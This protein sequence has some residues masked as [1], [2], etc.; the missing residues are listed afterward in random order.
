MVG[1][2]SHRSMEA[3]GE[4]N[5]EVRINAPGISFHLGENPVESDDGAG[6]ASEA[7]V[8]ILERGKS[9]FSLGGEW[10]GCFPRCL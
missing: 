2:P 9:H 5:L 8:K 4:F 1:P 10:S 7:C 6:V 3:L